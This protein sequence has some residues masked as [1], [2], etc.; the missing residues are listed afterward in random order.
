MDPCKP[1]YFGPTF[2][3]RRN[4]YQEVNQYIVVD[5]AFYSYF[6]YVEEELQELC[7]PPF[8]AD[9][10]NNIAATTK[11]DFSIYPDGS[12]VLPPSGPNSGLLNPQFTWEDWGIEIITQKPGAGSNWASNHPPQL[13]NSSNPSGNDFGEF[14][15][16]F[17]S[18]CFF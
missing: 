15:S 2:Y 1:N 18:P 5:G 8:E 16:S 14:F 3:Y 10:V 12:P 11:L 6:S 7:C 17:L 4:P 9:F 13:F